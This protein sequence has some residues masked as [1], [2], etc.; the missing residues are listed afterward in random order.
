MLT[1]KIPYFLHCTQM[2]LKFKIKSCIKC[3]LI[4]LALEMLYSKS[5]RIHRKSY[6][7]G[8]EVGMR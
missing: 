3:R 8:N 2:V 4:N 5:N 7:V 1:R 6:Q